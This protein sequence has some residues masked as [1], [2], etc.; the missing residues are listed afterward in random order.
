MYMATMRAAENDL[1]LPDPGEMSYNPRRLLSDLIEVQAAILVPASDGPD[2][3]CDDPPGYSL[4]AT[5]S[6]AAATTATTTT[7]RM[8]L[9]VSLGQGGNALNS[10]SP[11][12]NV[13]T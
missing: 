3:H 6:T 8:G 12:T 1:E 11:L 2:E 4:E 10:S 13:D 7:T 9:M 5:A